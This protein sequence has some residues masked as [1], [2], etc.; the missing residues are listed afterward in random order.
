[1]KNTADRI[2]DIN[3]SEIRKMFENASPDAISL[4]IGEPDFDTPPHI[5][6]ALKKA[7]DNKQTHYAHNKGLIELREAIQNKLKKDNNIKTDSESILVTV[8]ASQALYSSIQALINKGDEVIIPDPGFL[9][10]QACVKLAEGTPISTDSTP[11]N[12]FNITTDKIE[13]KITPKTKAI[14]LNSPSNPTGTVIKK[15]DIKGISDLA[16]DNDLYIITDEIYENIIYDKKHYSVASF[17]DNAITINGFSKSYA[18]TGLR[19]GYLAAPPEIT[20]DILKVHQYN[21]ASVDTPTQYAALEALNGSQQ[22]VIDMVNE[23]RKRRDY[24]VERLNN[25]GLTCK[26]PDGAFYIF[27]KVKNTQEFLNKASKEGVLVVSGKAFGKNAEDYIRI[28]YATSIENLKIA[29]DRLEK[30]V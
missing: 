11:D 13:D 27:L 19:I 1:M 10:Y 9:S 22:C 21:I 29:M 18:M 6:N 25:M 14:V 28:S 4:A 23:F 30:I 17:T 2:K 20:E 24:V 12:N 7:L 16:T 8:G 5:I 26:I 3:L 15:E